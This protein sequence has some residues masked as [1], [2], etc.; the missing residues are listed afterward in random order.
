MAWFSRE[1]AEHSAKK[2][3]ATTT[4]TGAQTEDDHVSSVSVCTQTVYNRNNK[5]NQV[6]QARP[7]TQDAKLQTDLRPTTADQDCQARPD[8]QDAK[9]Q[10]DPRKPTSDQATQAEDRGSTRQPAPPPPPV[11][12]RITRSTRPEHYDELQ[13]PDLFPRAPAK[14]PT[15]T[16]TYKFLYDDG[17]APRTTPTTLYR[18][19]TPVLVADLDLS[20]RSTAGRAARRGYYFDDVQ[21]RRLYLQ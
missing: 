15:T 16:T 12:P 7:N 1:S 13:D 18:Y 2:T 3:T 9:Q 5:R 10:T 6:C 21:G 4:E 19:D 8:N 11:P 14:R 17:T 20:S